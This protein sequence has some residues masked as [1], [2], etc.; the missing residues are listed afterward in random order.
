MQTYKINFKQTNKQ[1][2]SRMSINLLNKFK[3]HT[4]TQVWKELMQY[5]TRVVH[6]L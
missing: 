6:N 5:P 4:L 3:V 1:K 2:K